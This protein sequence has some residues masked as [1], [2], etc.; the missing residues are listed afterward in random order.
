MVIRTLREWGRSRPALLALLLQVLAAVAALAL[1]AGLRKAGWLLPLPGLLLL[2]A[3]LALAA[4]VLLQQPRWWW[5][6]HLSFA[7]GL[8][9]AS[10]GEWASG[11]LLAGFALLALLNWNSLGE[12]VPLYLTGRATEHELQRLLDEL[13]AGFRFVD[14]GCGLAGTL[15]RLAQR[16]PQSS[17]TGVETAP[18]VF[19]LA[20]LRSR[21]Q[22]NC[23]VRYRSLWDEPLQDYEVVYCF[24][25]PAPMPRLWAKVRAE[26]PPGGLLI[27]NSFAIPGV[28]PQGE[29]A[30]QD[31]RDSRLLLW[32][33]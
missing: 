26:M 10:R 33:L 14:L 20:W 16:Y 2:Q 13:P 28:P 19:A 15:V 24:L 4:S 25:S 8:W 23:Q 21:G 12:R 5:L 32:R 11:W 31:W 1:H 7:P 30:L 29:I 17:F 27:S 18:L 9:L 6:I 22:V 3:L